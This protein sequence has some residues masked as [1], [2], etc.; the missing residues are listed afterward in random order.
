MSHFSLRAAVAAMETVIEH[1]GTLDPQ[2]LDQHIADSLAI[3]SEL[4]GMFADGMILIVGR[5]DVEKM[6]AATLTADQTE[7]DDAADLEGVRP[8]REMRV[9]ARRAANRLHDIRNILNAIPRCT[10]APFAAE[11]ITESINATNGRARAVPE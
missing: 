2:E 9:A 11:S 1:M 3:V 5:E 10:M 7:R 8:W 4:H 6:F